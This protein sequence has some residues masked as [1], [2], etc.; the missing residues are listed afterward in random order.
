VDIEYIEPAHARDDFRHLWGADWIDALSRYDGLLAIRL[1]PLGAYAIGS[2]ARYET[3][4]RPAPERSIEVLANF[5]V[6]ATADLPTADRLVLDAYATRTA[7]RVWT[8]SMKSLLAAID[9]GRALDDLTSFLAERAAHDVPVTVR[10]LLDDV[11]ARTRQVRDLGVH[12]VVECADPAVATL[13]A[14]DRTLR[15]HCTRVGDRHLIIT[16]G[17][18]AKVR[19]ALRNLGYALGPA[20]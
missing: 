12:R 14:N 17:G 13:L 18:E 4:R 3:S 7:D 5:D 16:V 8:L 2:S 11:A 20:V 10:S 9:T 6:V 1:N 19:T 15:A